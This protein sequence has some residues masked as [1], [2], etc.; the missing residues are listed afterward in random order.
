MNIVTD[1]RLIL[2]D[3][4]LDTGL[5]LL[6]LA[7]AAVWATA[8]AAIEAGPA[9]VTRSLGKSHFRAAFLLKRRPGIGVQDLSRLT[10]LSKQ[11]A[12]KVLSDLETEGLIQREAADHDARR[13]PA[14]LTASG[15]AF[16]ARISERL[17]TQLAKAYRVGGLDAVGGARRILSALAG[18]RL[19]VGLDKTRQEPGL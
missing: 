11:G 16:E 12:S 18:P 6:F 3:D 7:E 17:R 5:E 2:H 19:S 1:T 14:H 8:D 10:G 15:L 9:T 13:R 4:A